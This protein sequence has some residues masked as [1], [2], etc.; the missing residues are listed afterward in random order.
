MMYILLCLVLPVA[1]HLLLLPL[2]R[3]ICFSTSL[4]IQIFQKILSIQLRR[5]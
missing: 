5:R 4:L 2:L 3:S 1:I